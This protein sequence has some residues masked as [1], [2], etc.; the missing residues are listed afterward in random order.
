MLKRCRYILLF[1]IALFS[2]F[3]VAGQSAMPDNVCTGYSSHYYVNSDPGSIYTWWIDGV[4]QPEFTSD[5]FIHTWNAQGIYLL[6]VQ[7]KSANGCLGPVMSGQVIV[8]PLPSLAASETNADVCCGEGKIVF[9]FTNVHDGTYSISYD[10]G[11]FTDV[12]VASGIAS[13]TAPEGIYSNLSITIAGC[14]STESANIILKRLN[15]IK[16]KIP[17]AFSP[18]GDLINDVWNIG[19]IDAYP[20]VVITIYNRWGQ[21]LWKSEQGYPHPWDGKSNGVNLPIDSYHY[22]IDLHNGSKQIVGEITIV[23]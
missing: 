17:E 19:N 10:S 8:S 11:I 15:N 16:L 12:T 7:E 4:V 1:G 23:R 18:N 13:V 20:K 14:T 3:I 2:A 21:S 6:E 9:T 22:I 5:S